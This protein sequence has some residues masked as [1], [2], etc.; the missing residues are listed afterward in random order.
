MRLG[1]PFGMQ[2]QAPVWLSLRLSSAGQAGRRKEVDT[3]SDLGLWAA[4]TAKT[5]TETASGRNLDIIALQLRILIRSFRLLF[6]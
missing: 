2:F 1:L 4:T 5:E 3:Q 6:I